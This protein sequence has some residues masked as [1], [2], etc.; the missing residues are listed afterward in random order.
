MLLDD[1]VLVLAVQL[2]AVVVAVVVVFLLFWLFRAATRCQAMRIM[3]M[4]QSKETRPAKRGT[5]IKASR[6]LVENDM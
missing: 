6:S 2:V 4:A 3:A 1:R 5:I